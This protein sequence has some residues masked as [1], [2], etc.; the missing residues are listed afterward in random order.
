MDVIGTFLKL[1]H[2]ALQ[3]AIEI[4]ETIQKTS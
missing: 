2:K 4:I 1:T 3:L